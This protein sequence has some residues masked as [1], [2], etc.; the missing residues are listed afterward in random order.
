MK[1]CLF[2]LLGYSPV[3]S[4]ESQ[5]TFGKNMSPISSGSKKISQVR[6]QSEAG[7]KNAALMLDL[8]FDPIDGSDIF[9]R[10]VG[11]LSADYM[12]LYPRRQNS[13]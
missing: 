11:L 6:N 12:A 9:R 2:S 7:S 13:S 4:V 1:S 3:K 5:L 10:N 8:Y